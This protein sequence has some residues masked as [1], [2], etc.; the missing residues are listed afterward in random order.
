MGYGRPETGF[1]ASAFVPCMTGKLKPIANPG[2]GQ[3]IDRV[4]GVSLDFLSQ[5]ADHNAQD[6]RFLAMVWA[7]DSAQDFLMRNHFPLLGH[8]QAQNSE[9]CGSQMDSLT[10]DI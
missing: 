9:F 1:A 10:A 7:P 2:F 5:L 8:K 4:R 3:D 6:L